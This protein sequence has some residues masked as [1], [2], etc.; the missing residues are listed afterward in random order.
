MRL[1]HRFLPSLLAA[2]STLTPGA[3]AADKTRCIDQHV[4]AQQARLEGK[5]RE[6]RSAL[7][8]CSNPACPAPI[9]GE[10]S[11][12]LDEVRA[13]IPSVVVHARTAAGGELPNARVLIDGAVAEAAA[14]PQRSFEL[15]PGAH[16][17][18]AEAPGFLPAEQQILLREGEQGHA[19]T[20][21]LQANARPAI[22][23]EPQAKPEAA[24]ARPVP[25][26]VPILGGLAAAGA[27]SFT[28]FL[29]LGD[30]IKA[31]LD[32]LGCKPACPRERVDA[33]QRYYIAADISAGIGLASAL[34]AAVLF[35]ARPTARPPKT[36]AVATPH[37][38]EL[39]VS[40]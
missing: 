3:W 34:A 40:F 19:V 27:T 21:T 37:G 32:Q 38:F 16:V 18:R 28:V 5:L 23:A 33:A 6:A 9:P 31:D 36:V 4:V 25:P 15:D 7:G 1:L 8:E 35:V 24:L 11:N 39:S 22:A 26:L 14:G 12:W 17:V 20:L 10:C 30:D 2:V 13:S 29:L